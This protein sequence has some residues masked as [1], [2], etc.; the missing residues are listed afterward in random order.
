MSKRAN[1]LP[2]LAPQSIVAQSWSIAYQELI[3]LIRSDLVNKEST[4][5]YQ[6]QM[7]LPLKESLISD[8]NALEFEA[9]ISHLGQIWQSDWWSDTFLQ[10][11][12]SS[13]NDLFSNP[14]KLK[15]QFDET[16]VTNRNRHI[17]L[18]HL[19]DE[20]SIFF[21]YCRERNGKR[22]KNSLTRLRLI[23]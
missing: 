17:A 23:H 20:W 10:I 6:A 4:E 16:S 8:G 19:F 2:A 5:L 1:S 11:V 14:F 22:E 13:V 7:K 18:H 21:D 12:C 15:W 3:D 9:L